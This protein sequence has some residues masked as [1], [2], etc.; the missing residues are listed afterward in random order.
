MPLFLSYGLVPF[1]SFALFIQFVCSDDFQRYLISPALF[2]INAV[3]FSFPVPRVSAQI[4]RGWKSLCGGCDGGCSGGS[5]SDGGAIGGEDDGLLKPWHWVISFTGN[6]IRECVRPSSHF[7]VYQERLIPSIRGRA[8]GAFGKN[9]LAEGC[10][11][12]SGNYRR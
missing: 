9:L 7:S 11:L 10:L 12:S 6:S 3:A 4:S 1:C 8:E 2:I 5:D